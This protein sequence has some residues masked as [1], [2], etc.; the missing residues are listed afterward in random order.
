MALSRSSDDLLFQLCMVSHPD[1]RVPTAREWHTL[2]EALGRE[3]LLLG[4]YGGTCGVMPVDR[5]LHPTD[6][7]LLLS[8]LL[9]HTPY[10]HAE[11]ARPLPLAEALGTDVQD[12][13]RASQALKGVAAS[14]WQAWVQTQRAGGYGITSPPRD[15]P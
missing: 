4:H 8:G 13:I 2:R 12:L 5:Q 11:L 7:A 1:E 15:P 14:L 9:L 3:G 6:G 10:R